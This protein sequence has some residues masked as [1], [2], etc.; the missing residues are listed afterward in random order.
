M[1]SIEDKSCYIHGPTQ[2]IPSSSVISFEFHKGNG[3]NRSSSHHRTALGKPTPLKWDDAQK[4]LVGL[5]R[6]GGGGEKNQS[7]PR[8]S[9]ANDRRL[10]ASVPQKDQDYFSS[11]DNAGEEERNGRCIDA[12]AAHYDVETKNDP[13]LQLDC[14]AMR[15]IRLVYHQQ[16]ADRGEVGVA[17]R[18]SGGTRRYGDESNTCKIAENN[19]SDQ[20]RKL[21]NLESQAIA[22]DV[23]NTWQVMQ[24]L[25]ETISA[26]PNE[27]EFSI[28][29]YISGIH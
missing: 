2:E 21:S 20:A 28:S 9:N 29:S 24:K 6:G 7:K 1:R 18:G 15:V 12:V 4:W 3:A 26:E 19:D 10:I 27:K 11:N 17:G 16:R 22:W 13:Q 25:L 14:R 23:L 8:N 5:S